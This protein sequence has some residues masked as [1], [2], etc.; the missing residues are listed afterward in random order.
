MNFV[1]P[2]FVFNC[3]ANFFVNLII[4]PL[5]PPHRPLSAEQTNNNEVFFELSF[6]LQT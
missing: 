2:P 1:L 3:S 5:N 4:E 6:F